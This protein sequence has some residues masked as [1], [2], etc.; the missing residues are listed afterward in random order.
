MHKC[1]HCHYSFPDKDSLERHLNDG[2]GC[3]EAP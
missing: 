1:P 3:P 2:G